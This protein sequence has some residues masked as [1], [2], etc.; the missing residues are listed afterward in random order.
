MQYYSYLIEIVKTPSSINH[1]IT[2]LDKKNLSKIKYSIEHILLKT[3]T[4]S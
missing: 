1:H 2:S 4:L 3:D